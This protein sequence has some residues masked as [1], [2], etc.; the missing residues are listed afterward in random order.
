MEIYHVHVA[1]AGMG[2]LLLCNETIAAMPYYVENI[3]VNLYSLEELCYYITHNAYLLERDFMCE[4]LCT[5]VEKE[6]K[7]VQLADRL[8]DILREQGK[9]SDFVRIILNENGYCLPNEI[10]DVCEVILEME[11]KSD[12]ECSKIRADRL[13]EREK[14]LSCIYEYKRLLDSEDAKNE[15]ALIVGN[16]WHNLGTA[17]ARL[18]LF[19]EA[20]D[21]YRKAYQRNQDHASLKAELFA[22]RCMHDE[23]AFT[24]TAMENNLDDTAMQAIRNELTVL[25]RGEETSRF[26][27]KL[28]QIVQMKAQGNYTRYKL[29]LQEIIINWKEDYRYHV[30]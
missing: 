4:E 7:L 24:R 21:C 5:W 13:M 2:E 10:R 16:I 29:A 23:P 3:S 6:L 11:E 30:I 12:F 27:E 17:Y 19:E 20:A 9:L 14:Y 1:E 26:E 15:N 18:F 25:S 28:E 22:Y 8:R